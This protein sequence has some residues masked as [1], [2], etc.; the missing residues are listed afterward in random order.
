MKLLL[1][2]GGV[3][4]RSIA[5]T[6]QELI[7]KPASDT[8]IG[9]IPTAANIEVGNKDW[10]INQFLKLWRRGYNWIDIVDPS[11]ADVNWQVRLAECDVI[12]ISGGNTFYLL[13]QARKTGFDK[14]INDNKEKVFV[15]S[16]AGSILF[17]PNI[18]I[19]SENFGD[20][21]YSGLTDLKG[22]NWVNFEV[23]PHYEQSLEK[24][25]GTYAASID[26][27]LY[28]MDDQTAIK[29]TDSK[30]EVVS[31]GFWKVLN[32]K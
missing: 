25:I 8:K 10:A 28:A 17:T 13:D 1:T 27:P 2:S 11:V 29:V 18:K 32:K 7:D 21:N 26:H 6:L 24:A 5:C 20:E 31:E 19:A 22:L 15:G 9:F 30:V 16:S 4:N 12:F 14:W 23:A 3:D